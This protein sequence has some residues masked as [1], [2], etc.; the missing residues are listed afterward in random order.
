MKVIIAGGRD[1]KFTAADTKRLD[2]M[3][4]Q[5]NLVISGCARGAD[6]EG[7]AWAAARKIPVTRFQANWRAFGKVAGFIRNGH[8]A[9]FADCLIAFPGGRGTD[10]MVKQ[11]NKRG[12]KI[13]DWRT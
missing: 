8:M 1:Y 11:A 5:I 12:L 2:D 9:Q 4:D 6:Q 13:Y 7:E 10:D 3:A